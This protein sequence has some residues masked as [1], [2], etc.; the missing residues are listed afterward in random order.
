MPKTPFNTKLIGEFSLT[1]ASPDSSFVREGKV[2]FQL[3]DRFGRWIYMGQ[4]VKFKVRLPNGKY[5]SVI[6]TSSGQGHSDGARGLITVKN[7]AYLP[8]G[9]YPVDSKNLQQYVA[10]LSEKDLKDQ[11]IELG[12]DVSGNTVTAREDSAI[13]NLDDIIA[14][15]EEVTS[16]TKELR[17]EITGNEIQDK[18]IASIAKALKDEGRFPIPRESSTDTWGK[19]SDVT[20]GAKLDYAKVYEGMSS[21][22]PEFAQNYPTFD[23]FWK[24]VVNLAVDNTDQSPNDLDNIP[25]EMKDINKGYARHVL[26][27]DPDNGT[28]TV[29]RNA[30]NNW[31]TEQDSAVG[32]V[33]TNENFAWDYNATTRVGEGENG[34]YQITV[35]PDEVYGMIGYSQVEDEYGLTIGRGVTYQEGRVKKLGELESPPIAPWYDEA[36]SDVNRAQGATPFRHH[37]FVGQYDFLP[38]SKNPMP[39]DTIKDFL[40]ANNMTVEDFRNKFDEVNGEGAYQRYKDSG[41][42]VDYRR[43]QEMVVDLGDGTYGID[44]TKIDPMGQNYAGSASYGDTSDPSSFVNDPVDNRLKFLSLFQ[45]ILGEPFM[46]HKN[47]SRAEEFVQPEPTPEPNTKTNVSELPEGNFDDGP[48][49]NFDA[50]KFEIKEDFT[51]EEEYAVYEYQG[52]L[53]EVI[54]KFSRENPNYKA[55]DKPSPEGGGFYLD[56]T[57]NAVDNL[58]KAFDKSALGQDLTVYRGAYISENNYQA[59]LSLKEGDLLNDFGY[60][61]T[62]ANPEIAKGF[63]KLLPGYDFPGEADEDGNWIP[64]TSRTPVLYKINL[65]AGQSA[66][67]V[68]DHTGQTD[69]LN[70]EEVLLPRNSKLKVTKISKSTQTVGGLAMEVLLIE[71]EYDTGSVEQPQ[72]QEWKPSVREVFGRYGRMAEGDFVKPYPESKVIYRIERIDDKGDIFISLNGVG[73]KKTSPTDFVKVD[74]P[75]DAPE[76]KPPIRE[77][78]G[79]YGRVKEGDL[80]TRGPEGKVIYRIERIDDKGSISISLNGV[81]VEKTNSRD[82]VKVDAE[83]PAPAE[84]I[85]L[86]GAIEPGLDNWMPVLFDLLDSAEEEEEKLDSNSKFWRRGNILQSMFFEASG[87]NGK[88]KLVPKEEFDAIDGETL[89]R[90]V[91]DKKFVD[92]YINS[93]TQYAG[94]G[95]SGNGTYTTNKRETVDFYA[96]ESGNDRKI[97]NERTMEMKLAPDAN[98]LNLERTSDWR[99]WMEENVEILLKKAQE[100]GAD[101]RNIQS[102]KNKLTDWG[103]WSNYAIM[104]GYDGFR[105]SAGN[106]EHFTVI[107]N[108]G[109]VILKDK[110]SELQEEL[111]E[112][113]PDSRGAF[114]IPKHPVKDSKGNQVAPGDEVEIYYSVYEIGKGSKNAEKPLKATFTG[115][116][117]EDFTGGAVSGSSL[118]AIV[119]VSGQDGADSGYYT[120]NKMGL[121]LDSEGLE[122]LGGTSPI[123]IDQFSQKNALP[124][125]NQMTFL[126]R[127][128]GKELIDYTRHYGSFQKINSSLRD[129]S[130]DQETQ[131]KIE[132]LDKI[133]GYN[134]ILEDQEYYRGI[135]IPL[136]LTLK[137]FLSSLDSGK[138]TE[139]DELGFSSTSTEEKMASI[140]ANKYFGG[141]VVLRIKAKAGQ[142]VYYVPNFL[143]EVLANENEVILPRGL[144]YR[145]INYD[146]VSDDDRVVIDV[147]I[148]ESR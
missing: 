127:E 103:S 144:R 66:L 80:V 105:V 23:E 34:R 94:E 25:Q 7:D 37:S 121:N 61:S 44:I 106:N 81:G 132:I 39:G 67:R 93:E 11:G 64:D 104:L 20:K 84:D 74:A 52:S 98:I 110:S 76:W 49:E 4:T 57:L 43:M 63:A 107:L 55:G 19:T 91:T 116:T 117:A 145:I 138:I 123:D 13:P 90:A 113:T 6:G 73:V 26:G 59:A 70:E 56:S 128:E 21:E 129:D 29:Y 89:Y 35:K 126:T 10:L 85:E 125:P 96:G 8:D 53:Y 135:P 51:G 54:N 75:D 48:Q 143:T 120:V 108:R 124:N 115:Y 77:V 134:Q 36:L 92:D 40:E 82:F 42:T 68:R 22:N 72:E 102:I 62:S 111:E 133:I 114:S 137:E 142:N 131:E 71:T 140:F 5:H 147:E 97:I 79:K 101:P 88:P 65:K 119:Y 139:L 118:D 112:S 18:K 146:F 32:Y 95:T 15:A 130:V 122:S 109:K 78:L 17:S 141:G 86:D 24:R 30:I 46:V 31:E 38:V 58:D 9:N 45:E 69:F 14:E 60:L 16:P 83:V 28:F 136:G 87:F 100:F 99:A 12:K 148:E 1:A 33:T 2:Y 3:R 27:L 50:V 47:N 41:N